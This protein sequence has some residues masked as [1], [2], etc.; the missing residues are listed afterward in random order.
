VKKVIF[1]ILLGLALSFSASAQ[2]TSAPQ[3]HKEFVQQVYS[4][5]VLLYGQDGSGGMKMTCT[6][7]AY[8]RLADKS[9]YRFVSA[10]HCVSGKTDK[11]QK[12]QKYYITTDNAGEKI[13]L[14]AVLIEAGDK[15]VGDDFSI[16]EVK[17][18][19][20]FSVIPLGNSE[21]LVVGDKVINVASPYGLGKQYFEG[22]VSNTKLDRP[23]IDAGKVQW[24]DV[25]LIEVGSAGGSSGSA[26]ISE[27]QRAIVGFLVGGTQSTI[28]AICIPVNR[29]KDFEKAVKVGTYK[30]SKASDDLA[31]GESQ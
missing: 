31:G 5:V 22:Y 6:A 24:T 29:F 27:D 11:E 23:P 17:T 7:T 12:A 20:E 9:G 15:S 14:N 1:V 26:I 10:A 4:S 8:E 2:K 18:N 13:F 30:K 16:F 25:M 28:G 21:F 3:A 19:R